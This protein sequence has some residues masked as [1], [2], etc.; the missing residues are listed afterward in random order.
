MPVQREGY[1]KSYTGGRP[2]PRYYGRS[3][4]TGA[5][6]CVCQFNVRSFQWSM[7]T[8]LCASPYPTC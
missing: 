7:T 6:F 1:A 5:S 2:I 8:S 4:S 3:P